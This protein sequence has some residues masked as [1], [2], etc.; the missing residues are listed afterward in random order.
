MFETTKTVIFLA[1]YLSRSNLAATQT[2][3]SIFGERIADFGNYPNKIR[4][5]LIKYSSLI[6][7]TP[8]EIADAIR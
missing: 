5:V 8:W 6:S 4:E 2:F 7:R 1:V 3:K